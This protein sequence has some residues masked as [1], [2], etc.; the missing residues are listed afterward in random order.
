MVAH[1][2]STIREADRICVM[3]EGKI[4]EQGTYEELIHRQG[5]FSRIY[6]IQEDSDAEK[7]NESKLENAPGR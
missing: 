2:L 3:R 1:R 5:E 7:R 6:D 4:S